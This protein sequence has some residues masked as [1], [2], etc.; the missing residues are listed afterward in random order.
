MNTEHCPRAGRDGIGMEYSL[1]QARLP[2]YSA[3][4]FACAPMFPC[5]YLAVGLWTLSG[6]VQW[7]FGA[8]K[9]YPCIHKRLATRW[10]S[11]G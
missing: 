5:E 6:H 8:T 2:R 10:V 7:A 9:Q 11:K 4:C 3:H 1:V